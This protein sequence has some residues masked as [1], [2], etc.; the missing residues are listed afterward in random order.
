MTLRLFPRTRGAWIR[1]LI[2]CGFLAFVGFRFNVVP[3]I[4][5]YLYPKQE[6]DILFQSLP[7]EELVD[8]IEGITESPW[9]HCGV[10]ARRNDK[11]VVVEA[12]GVVR[13][14]P[15]HLW[16]AR[17]RGGRFAIYRVKDLGP[18]QVESVKR[19]LDGFLGLPYDFSYAP[20][21]REIYCS[22]L[23]YKSFEN[24][25]ALRLGEWER[26]GDL[27]WQ[28]F[29][30]FIRSMENGDLPLDRRMITP[31][32]LTRSAFVHPVPL[33]LH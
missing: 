12:L 13:E 31:V 14:T 11:W 33:R 8:A 10:L 2:S 19:S 25:T 6:G 23:V 26:L 27:R 20:D 18:E 17:G 9:S 4:A 32:A 7:R 16:V 1:L 29:E 28:P 21:D 3:V 24:G 5:A 15:L 30:P 22:E